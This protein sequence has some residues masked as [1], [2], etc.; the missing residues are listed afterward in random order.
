MHGYLNH[1]AVFVAAT[2][3][4]HSVAQDSDDSPWTKDQQLVVSAFNL[5]VEGVRGLLNDGANPNPRLGFYD[6]HLFEDKWTL[7]Y[8]HIGSNKWT[9]LLAV[10]NSHRAPQPEKR[11]ENTIEGLDAAMAKHNSLD[12]K[13]IV[14]RDKRRAQI[15]KLLLAGNA[16]LDADD[17]YG[18]TALSASIY[19][20]F[21]DLSLLL[22]EYGAKIDTKTGVYIDGDGDIAPM[23]RATKSPRVLSAL[24]KRGGNVNVAHSSGESP[25]HWAVRGGHVESVKVLIDAGANIFAKDKKGRPPSYW[26]E[27]FESPIPSPFLFPVTLKRN[28]SLNY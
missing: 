27:T 21:D 15:A 3:V 4:F 10:A 26:C 20:G 5:E 11:A 18:D 25:L 23:H 7:A 1:L 17:G 9:P 14:E 19:N 22:I 28:V 24:I 12:P 16:N 13:L 2:L 6:K 8:S